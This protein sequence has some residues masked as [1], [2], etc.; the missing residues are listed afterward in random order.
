MHATH[1]TCT[2]HARNI[3]ATYTTTQPPDPERTF[4][5]RRVAGGWPATQISRASGEVQRPPSALPC[6]AQARHFTRHGAA[7]CRRRPS[8]AGAAVARRVALDI[9]LFLPSRFV[10]VILASVGVQGLRSIFSASFQFWMEPNRWC[11][12]TTGSS[13]GMNVNSDER[14]KR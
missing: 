11:F 2:Q 3:H 10:R 5:F 9:F 13:P 4:A 6:V 1:A 12:I 8:W 7:I 14:R